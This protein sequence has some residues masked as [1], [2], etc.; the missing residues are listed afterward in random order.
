M[1]NTI[2]RCS[3]ITLALAACSEGNF[4]SE[5]QG[6]HTEQLSSVPQQSASYFTDP[7][8]DEQRSTLPDGQEKIILRKELSGY[9]AYG[10]ADAA[11]DILYTGESATWP[12]PLPNG[13]DARDFD[14]QYRVSLTMDD[15]DWV[16]LGEYGVEAWANGEL[17]ATQTLPPHGV[18]LGGPFTNWVTHAFEAQPNP[19]GFAFSLLNTS[20]TASGDWL[21]VDWVEL[22]LL[23]NK[24]SVLTLAALS[25]AAYTPAGPGAGGF[26]SVPSLSVTRNGF[27][28]TTYENGANVVIAFRGTEVNVDFKTSVTN[29]LADAS[30]VT[31][32]PTPQWIGA[33]REAETLLGAVQAARP[34]KRI[35]LTGHSLGGAIAQLLGAT[36]SL[37]T[38]SFNAP[39]PGALVGPN[40]PGGSEIVNYRFYGDSVSL[41]GRDHQLGT[42]KSIVP[43]NSLTRLAIDL[44][45]SEFLDYH[46][47]KRLRSELHSPDNSI[48]PGIVGGTLLKLGSNLLVPALGPSFKAHIRVVVAAAGAVAIDPV[49]GSSYT[50]VWSN[51][52]LLRSITVPELDGVADWKISTFDG[53]N[54]SAFGDINAGEEFVVDRGTKGFRFVPLDEHNAEGYNP[55]HF[56]FGVTFAADGTF[57]GDLSINQPPDCTTGK[58]SPAE[59][60]P[61]NGEMKQVRL[62][63]VTD[64][65]GDPLSIRVVG[66]TQDE[67]LTQRGTPDAVVNRGVLSLRAARQ[68]SGNGRVYRVIFV[69]TDTQGASCTGTVAVSVP[70]SRSPHGSAIDDGIIV[71]SGLLN[72]ASNPRHCSGRH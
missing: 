21:A 11:A 33:T 68:G 52:P 4:S 24:V 27:S 58:P 19:N 65:N 30:F 5:S 50:L 43:R 46:S 45:P 6:E 70:H 66:V 56:V 55:N 35:T 22:E 41:I 60:W 44:T 26:V 14:A 48:E 51:G 25:E 18:P 2:G 62:E 15:H 36:K 72:G 28:A 29:L 10:A 31:G 67:P 34:D 7:P 39:S 63:G 20:R 71:D 38:I 32:Q 49:P 17:A 42:T 69:A 13:V 40:A 1:L 57:E 16:S 9:Q 59:L 53:Q 64:I 61:P 54:W 47:M 3:L 12:F 37:R 8:A 23:P